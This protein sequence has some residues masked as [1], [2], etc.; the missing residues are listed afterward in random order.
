MFQMSKPHQPVGVATRMRIS[1]TTPD[2]LI[3]HALISSIGFHIEKFCTGEWKWL[4]GHLL[5][6]TRW[7]GRT[8]DV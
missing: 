3:A 2:T 7:H 4:A 1:T 6:N 8:M 5:E